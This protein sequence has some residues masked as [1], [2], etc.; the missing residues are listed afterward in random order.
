MDLRIH[1]ALMGLIPFLVVMVLMPLYIWFLKRK[2]MGQYIREDGP[3]H[4]QAKEGTPT[5]GG[6]IVII[7][8]LMGVP[9]ISW[10]DGNSLLSTEYGITLGVTL[11]L[12]GLGFLDDY[13]KIAKKQNKGL[14]GYA[15]LL[16][17][18]L[19]G[20]GVGF[21]MMAAFPVT[22]IAVFNW[23]ALELGWLYPVFSMFI[24]T[25]TS[26]AVN[27][28]DGLDG[29]AGGTAIISLLAF[30]LIFSGGY[31]DP[32]HAPS[33]PDLANFCI[34]LTGALLAF[35]FF[36]MRPAKIFMG[37]TGSLALGGALGTMAVLSQSEVWLILIG[38]VFLIEALSVILQVASFKLTGKRIFK[39]SPIHHHFELCGWSENRVVGS[40]IFFQ[41]LLCTTAVLLYNG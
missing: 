27:L 35:F 4:H 21:Y 13:L 41:A 33:Y 20:L 12:A 9:V 39:M 26:N 19:C 40:F 10:L 23:G 3:Q 29:L 22:Q 1:Y 28:T 7:G 30:A 17:Q 32:T 38:A 8:V 15:K 34:V 31:Q 2:M 16:I 6:V 25:G 14:S 18:A 11:L 37:D 5:S 36:N 24:V